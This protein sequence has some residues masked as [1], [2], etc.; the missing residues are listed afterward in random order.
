MAVPGRPPYA[1]DVRRRV[2]LTGMLAAV[3]GPPAAQGQ[4]AGDPALIG[5]V[6]E[7]TLAP[8]YLEALR[9]GLAER[10]WAEGRGFRIEPRSANGDL[11]RLPG[12]VA[13]LIGLGVRVIVTGIGTPVALAAKRATAKIPIVFVTGGDPVEF[14]IVTNAT[15]PGGNITG[16]G[17]GIRLIQQRLTLL[18]DASPRVKRVAFLANLTNRIHPR[19]LAAMEKAAAPLGVT[20]EEVGVFEPPELGDAFTRIRAGRFEALF[21][22][23]DAMFST[24]AAR[25]VGLANQARLP[26]AYADRV[27]PEAGGLMSLSVDFVALCRCAAGHV[28]RILRGAAPGDLPVDDADTFELVVN[29]KTAKAIGVTLPASLLRR[30]EVL[31]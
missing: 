3:C 30:A 2:F 22:P 31:S 1:R 14:G 6:S 26:A 7:R 18:R 8:R 4:P 24:H 23:G 20:L 9:R 29:A 17:G 10:G 19:I 15:K 28:D 12:V 16:C 21:V 13:E 27:F 5:F 11:E 25:L